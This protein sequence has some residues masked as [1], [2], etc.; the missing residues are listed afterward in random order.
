MADRG[1]ISDYILGEMDELDHDG[2]VEMLWRRAAG[3]V[4]GEEHERGP[5]ALAAAFQRIADIAGDARIKF[6]HL[7]LDPLLDCVEV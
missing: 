1:E 5:D 4:R 3:G 2:E 7:E 6:L